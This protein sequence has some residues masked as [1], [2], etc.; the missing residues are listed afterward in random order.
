[1]MNIVL[2]INVNKIAMMMLK[3]VI[4]FVAIFC[5]ITVVVVAAKIVGYK[6]VAFVL[7]IGIYALME[8]IEKF[9]K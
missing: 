3:E 4:T 8:T 2:N 6:V 7:L 9:N 1:M 5:L